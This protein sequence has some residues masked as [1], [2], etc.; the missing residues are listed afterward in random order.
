MRSTDR[1]GQLW[2]LP[3]T[4]NQAK[5]TSVPPQVLQK[6]QGH[7]SHLVLG[8]KTGYHWV[9]AMEQLRPLHNA[10]LDLNC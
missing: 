1:K 8:I 5:E 4:V 7:P 3:L 2:S 10:D 9:F 6:R